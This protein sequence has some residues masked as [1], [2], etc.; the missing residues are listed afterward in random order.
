M[1]NT[2]RKDN[3]NRNYG[4]P[5]KVPLKGLFQDG[6]WHCITLFQ[7]PNTTVSANKPQAIANPASPPPTS[8][9][10]KKAQIKDVGSTP[11]RNPR[12]VA[13]DSFYGMNMLQGGR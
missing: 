2:P 5:N 4:I 3:R 1:Y 13:V 11:A 10:A 8:W 9:S 12:K 7:I 6:I